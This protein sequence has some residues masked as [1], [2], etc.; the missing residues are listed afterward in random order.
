MPLG[1]AIVG[2]MF[3]LVVSSTV[4]PKLTVLCGVAIEFA[5]TRVKLI[6]CRLF[7]ACTFVSL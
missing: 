7:V 3:Q 4:A 5:C 2:V 1:E 6:F